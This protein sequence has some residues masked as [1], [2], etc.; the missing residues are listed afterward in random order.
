MKN[1]QIETVVNIQVEDAICKQVFGMSRKDFIH[2]AKAFAGKNWQFINHRDEFQD[3]LDHTSIEA[4]QA[5][6]EALNFAT[7]FIRRYPHTILFLDRI[8]L[9]TPALKALKPDRIFE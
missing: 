1:I 3:A 2:R 4:L 7:V 9:A 5:Y 8:I 6:N